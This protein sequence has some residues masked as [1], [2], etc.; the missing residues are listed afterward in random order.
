MVVVLKNSD[1]YNFEDDNTISVASK[2]RDTLLETLK[3]NPYWQY[4]GSEII[5]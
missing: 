1:I 4:I 3:M 2:K 5:T